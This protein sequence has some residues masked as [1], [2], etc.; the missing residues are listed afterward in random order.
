MYLTKFNLTISKFNP[1]GAVRFAK[2]YFKNNLIKAIEVGTF[3]GDN[4]N[5]IL[6][7]LNVKEIVLIDPYEDYSQKWASETTYRG[8]VLIDAL[9]KMKKRFRR[10]LE[11]GKV[12]FIKKNS[13]NALNDIKKKYD[14][15]YIDANHDY[16][17]VL[18]DLENYWKVLNVNGLLCGDD[19]D[20]P[21][22]FQALIDFVNKHKLND[23]NL[24]VWGRDF[25]IIKK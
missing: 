14:L 17:Y 4:A 25:I 21:F 10:E 24:R 16:E 8:K 12:I 9:N 11:S 13:D 18:R 23:G 19:I 2:E 15:I 20:Q 7:N 1:R 6:K 5:A 22:V 3:K